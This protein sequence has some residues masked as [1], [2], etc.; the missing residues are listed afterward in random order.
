MEPREPPLVEMSGRIRAVPSCGDDRTG[1]GRR[2]D[3]VDTTVAPGI[4]SSYPTVNLSGLRIE[5]SSSQR[6]PRPAVSKR[7]NAVFKK[8]QCT[9]LTCDAV[10][11]FNFA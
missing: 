9:G 1:R 8:I 2:D 4:N 5:R 3:S 11:M 6:S 10:S 7:I